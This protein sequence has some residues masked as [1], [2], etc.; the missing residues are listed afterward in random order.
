MESLSDE[1]TRDTA[2]H[3]A[4]SYEREINNIIDN[5][6]I[7]ATSKV[8][9]RQQARTLIQRVLNS[10]NLNF[11]SLNAAL[12][13]IKDTAISVAISSHNAETITTEVRRIEAAVA[14]IAKNEAE[15]AEAMR[16]A[17]IAY[18]RSRATVTIGDVLTQDEHGIFRDSQGRAYD[19][20]GNLVNET[21]V[22]AA[23]G[24]TQ[25]ASTEEIARA[26]QLFEEAKES[27][28]TAAIRRGARRVAEARGG[29]E[30]DRLATT[31]TTATIAT[32]QNLAGTT[33]EAIANGDVG[34][35]IS[36]VGTAGEAGYRNL[37]S[38]PEYGRVAREHYNRYVSNPQNASRL[39]A[40]GINSFEQFEAYRQEI[41]DISYQQI[42]ALRSSTDGE[43]ELLRLGNGNALSYEEFTTAIDAMRRFSG[44]T[45][46]DMASINQR[47]RNNSTINSTGGIVTINDIR[48]AMNRAGITT[49]EADADGD[50][51]IERNEIDAVLAR[52]SGGADRDGNGS[53]SAGEQAFANMSLADQNRFLTEVRERVAE[54]V[55]GRIAIAGADANGDRSVTAAE[56]AN[57]L[58]NRGI[59]SADRIDSAAEFQ[60]IICS[61]PV[62]STTRN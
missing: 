6:D 33:G 48:K 17:L 26:E 7:D 47:Y 46:A 10:S 60:A 54:C 13:A 20:V 29:S 53:V 19:A 61:R 41:F 55:A 43:W 4:D 2:Q 8:L 31:R 12:V 49:S 18:R 5:S 37:V 38:D 21:T 9:I 14:Q 56:A 32:A 59:I 50:G 36:N 25:A 45:A 22:S 30:A 24:T 27:G 39:R 15:E 23:G 58:I 52:I 62:Q 40:M 1:V 34:T 35:V 3:L 11:S 57:A 51:R 28:D 16:Q 42:A 44:L